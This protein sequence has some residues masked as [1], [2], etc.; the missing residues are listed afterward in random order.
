MKFHKS[1]ILGF[2]I[3]FMFLKVTP[4]YGKEPIVLHSETAVLMDAQTG[5]VL[6]DQESKRTMYPASITKIV[7]AIIAIETGVLD[8]IVV[9]PKEA[10][11]VI[12]TKVYLLEE[13]EVPLLTLVQGLLINSGND[14]ATAIAYHLSGGEEAFA[15]EMNRFIYEQ[16]GVSNTHFTNPHG[17]Y[18]DNHVT[19]AYDMA[20]ITQY[21]M[22]NELFREIVAT[23]ELDWHG[24]GWETTIYNHHRMLWDYE[25]VTGVK[26]GYVSQSGY[27]LVTTAMHNGMELIAVTLN[28]PSASLAYADT[29]A[30]LDYGF[31]TFELNTIKAG[32]IFKTDTKKQFYVEEDIQYVQNKGEKT[33]VY[34]NDSG[35]LRIIDQHNNRLTSAILQSLEMDPEKKEVTTNGNEQVENR[36]HSISQASKRAPVVRL[37]KSYKIVRGFT[38][39]STSRFTE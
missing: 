32:E 33:N 23:K 20:K 10:T 1:L 6:F 27:T 9:V 5:Q 13:E 15:Q 37:H 28:S 11:D 38:K 7:T 21:A 35:L 12:G 18:D 19:T 17:L 4:L 26:N 2:V 25:G 34:V 31:D 29:A 30:L 36:T 22:Q 24:E 16:I 14:A 3:L 39:Y 8:D